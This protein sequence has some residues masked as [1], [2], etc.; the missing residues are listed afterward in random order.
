MLSF[1]PKHY[2][3][4]VIIA[5]VVAFLSGC[6][7]DEGLSLGGKKNDSQNQGANATQQNQTVDMQA[8]CGL[9]PDAMNDKTKPIFQQN[10]QSLPIV[11]SGSMMVGYTV[12]TQANV[13]ISSL[14]DQVTQNIDV[15]VLD[16]KTTSNIFGIPM[17][18]AK[19]K[20]KDATKAKSGS[21]TTY[22][23]SNGAWLNLTTDRNQ[24]AYNG[25]FCAVAGT[26]K[27]Q[28]NTG[29]ESGEV[30]FTPALVN[31]INPLAPRA[32]I[33]KELGAT[34]RV[35]PVTASI[36]GGRKEW[37]SGT[38]QGTITITQIPATTKVG[39]TTIAGDVAFEIRADFAVGANKVGVSR[40]QKF[41][42]NTTTHTIEAIIDDSGATDPTS[43]AA[44]PPTVLMR[45]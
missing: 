42:L 39:E 19:G 17:A 21:V 37:A 40:N 7:A 36:S 23:M 2:H 14:S 8:Q 30:Q 35:F 22:R 24:P 45:K 43:N 5:V 26:S 33:D 31:A 44:L 20:A 4:T 15:Q 25:L 27:I 10:L 16:V 18:I 38:Q 29:G 34:P 11:V 1:K 9:P 3:V 12:I 6:S 41:F 28:N 32:T 13:S